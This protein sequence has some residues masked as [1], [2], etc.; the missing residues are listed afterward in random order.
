VII[1]SVD[2]VANDVDCFGP[3]ILTH[4]VLT[5]HRPCHINECSILPLNK[6]IRLWSVLGRELMSNSKVIK[7]LINSSVLELTTIV[8]SNSLDGCFKLIM[9]AFDK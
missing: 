3:K 9:N 1:Q 6:A 2:V 8:T 4:I 7:Q 5:M